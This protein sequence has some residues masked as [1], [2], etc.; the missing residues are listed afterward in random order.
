M[1]SG[2]F[3]FLLSILPVSLLMIELI[4]MY[5][6]LRLPPELEIMTKEWGVITLHVWIIIISCLWPHVAHWT[7]KEEEI[8]DFPVKIQKQLVGRV[9]TQCPLYEGIINVIDFVLSDITHYI[10]EEMSKTYIASW[11][12][13]ICLVTLRLL[14]ISL[15]IHSHHSHHSHHTPQ[16]IQ[17]LMFSSS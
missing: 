1:E 6:T 17:E 14:R 8:K 3:C 15:D 4:F 16:V 2:L 5:G 12:H 11:A 10:Y 7:S 13:N 9:W